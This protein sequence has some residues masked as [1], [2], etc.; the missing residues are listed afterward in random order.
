MSLNPCSLDL[1]PRDHTTRRVKHLDFAAAIEQASIAHEG[2]QRGS[3]SDVGDFTSS[4]NSIIETVPTNSFSPFISPIFALNHGA[5]GGSQNQPGQMFSGVS[6]PTYPT[7]SAIDTRDP[8]APYD[9]TQSDPSNVLN[10][11]SGAATQIPNNQ[12]IDDI[13]TQLLPSLPRLT[14]PLVASLRQDTSDEYPA[15]TTVYNPP[16]GPSTTS[17][18]ASNSPSLLHFQQSPMSYTQQSFHDS[19][20]PHTPASISSTSQYIYNGIDDQFPSPPQKKRK[21]GPRP[22]I[23]DCDMCDKSFN[24][25]SDL[26]RHVRTHTGSNP[27]V[28]DAPGCGKGFKQVR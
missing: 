25:P 8:D 22:R 21:M 1:G 7:S 4:A 9:G 17:N 10:S 28:C 13:T 15:E 27:F 23:Y 18:S 3:L 16:G 24:R 2:L 12:Q 14:D 11:T 26:E 6:G 19:L 5:I 20:P